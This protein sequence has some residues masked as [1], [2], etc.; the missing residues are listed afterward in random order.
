VVILFSETSYQYIHDNYVFF[1]MF[2]EF[3]V[4]VV[5]AK[6]MIIRGVNCEMFLTDH[7]MGD[8]LTNDPFRTHVGI[9]KKVIIIK[10]SL[11]RFPNITHWGVKKAME[12]LNLR[13]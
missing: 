1:I 9:W 2:V 7:S 5:Q 4:F 3:F 13:N 6:H 11:D 8:V 10:F 12:H